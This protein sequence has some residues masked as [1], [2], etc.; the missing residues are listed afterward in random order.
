MTASGPESSLAAMESKA[1]APHDVALPT[2]LGLTAGLLRQGLLLALGMASHASINL[3][4]L[5]LVGKLGPAA[6]AGVHVASV[7]NFI[8]MIVGNGVSVASIAAMSRALGA[9]RSEDARRISARAF[10]WMLLLGAVIGLVL[11]AL[12]APCVDL[13][14]ATGDARAIGI[15]YLVVANLGTVSMFALMQ[16]SASMRAAGEVWM[17]VLLLVGA[18]VVNLALDVLFLF[19]W[20]RVGV[21][22]LGAPGAAYASVV[23]RSAFGFLGVWWLGRAQHPARIERLWLRGGPLGE[24][25]QLLLVGLPQSLQM[26]VRTAVVIAL[27]RVAGALSGQTALTALGVTTRLDTVVLFSAAGFASAGTAMVG[28]AIGSG[29]RARARRAANLTAAFAFAVGCA[30]ALVVYAAAPTLLRFFVEGADPAVVEIGTDYLGVAVIGHAFGCYALGATAGVNGAGRT[31]PPLLLDASVYL[32]ALPVAMWA[33]TRAIEPG[34]SL[35]LLWWG[36]TAVNAVLAV[37]HAVYVQ[38]GR[39]V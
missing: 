21:P 9:G 20:E 12:S 8:P 16:T 14:G 15:H 32:A 11:A 35:V 37:A 28:H 4:D 22:S 29:D 34:G 38:V 3:V 5:W 18:N 27:T 30:V 25:R 19:G 7:V 33:A 17:P 36:L 10:T 2:Q 23:A 1:S 31:V 6:V 24:L 26:V 39:W 13:Q